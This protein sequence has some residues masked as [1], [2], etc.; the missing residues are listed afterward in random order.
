MYTNL[1]LEVQSLLET[2]FAGFV[3]VLQTKK[4]S[5]TKTKKM[6]KIKS[7]MVKFADVFTDPDLYVEFEAHLAD[8]Q[9]LKN[10]HFYRAV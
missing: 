4:V 5:S 7:G 10:L 6:R 3:A 8:A 1:W 2:T 9:A